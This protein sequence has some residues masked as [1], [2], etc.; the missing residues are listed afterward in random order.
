MCENGTEMAEDTQT[1]AL[2]DQTQCLIAPSCTESIGQIGN[3]F[4]CRVEMGLNTRF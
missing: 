1:R 2:S 3:K 4:D